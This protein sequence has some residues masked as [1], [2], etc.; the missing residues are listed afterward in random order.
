MDLD[1]EE[2]F[3]FSFR[4]EEKSF[5]YGKNK[6]RKRNFNLHFGCKF[7]Y[8]RAYV[9]YSKITLR[10]SK[11]FHNY[12]C[13]LFKIL[14]SWIQDFFIKIIDSYLQFKFISTMPKFFPSAYL[15][16]LC[17]FW[18]SVCLKA[19]FFCQNQKWV[20][21]NAHFQIFALLQLQFSQ[22]FA[23]YNSNL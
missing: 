22:N 1:K 18:N 5:F 13:A 8:L 2:L 7:F 23:L 15:L 6:R 9:F 10:Y 19:R 12:D 20:I 17:F 16:Q 3:N 21:F 14:S 4:S 11:F